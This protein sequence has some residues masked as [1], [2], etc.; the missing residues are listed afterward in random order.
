VELD[1]C[2]L[3]FIF[4]YVMQLAA[5]AS[6]RRRTADYIRL[7]LG[8]IVLVVGMLILAKQVSEELTLVAIVACAVV[9]TG[10]SLGVPATDDE[11]HDPPV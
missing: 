11:R 2:A 8:N 9:L 6:R 7:A 5:I 4:V 1:M 10:I 3:F